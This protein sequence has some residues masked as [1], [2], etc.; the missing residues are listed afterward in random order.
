M[1]NLFNKIKAFFYPPRKVEAL[2]KREIEKRLRE[3]GYSRAD[4]K[5]LASANKQP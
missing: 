5:R 1:R 3:Q 2:G 4:A